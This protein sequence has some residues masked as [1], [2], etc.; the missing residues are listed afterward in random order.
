[1]FLLIVGLG[2]ALWLAFQ[3]FDTFGDE[4]EAL[5]LSRSFTPGEITALR[6]TPQGWLGEDD[7][8]AI[9]YRFRQDGEE[10]LGVSFARRADDFS[11][12]LCVVEVH[13]E[14]ESIHR[15]SGTLLDPL[16]EWS[17]RLLGFGAAPGFAL[18]LI[19]LRSRLLTRSTAANE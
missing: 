11:V 18:V 17:R 13:P 16:P 3:G 2:S 5:R 15:V 7:L 6:P 14:R 10:S 8:V 19:W 4:D 9:E 1:M 12:G